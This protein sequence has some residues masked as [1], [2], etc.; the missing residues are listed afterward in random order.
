M[1]D[2]QIVFDF[3]E[4]KMPF[5]D[6][7]KVFS[8]NP[9]IAVW[10]DE[11]ADF[12]HR[13]IPDD[14]YE[15]FI[16]IQ[17]ICC[18]IDDGHIFKYLEKN[19]YPPQDRFT[20]EATARCGIFSVVGAALTAAYPEVKPTKYYQQEDDFYFD[21]IPEALMN[22]ELEEYFEQVLSEFPASMGKTKR[23][24]A[25]REK[26]K[27]LFHIEGRKYPRWAQESEWPMGKNSPMKFI[28][29]KQD[30]DQ[31]LFWFEDVD[32]GEERVIEQ[33]Y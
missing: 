14:L 32:T 12:K 11:I 4:G 19:P 25:A 16:G 2:K 24:K 20:R 30:E 21:A 17:A 15:A 29:Q 13:P 10:L 9:E 18:K 7:W 26:I 6:F 23:K 28:R 8:I 31:V 27:E 22:V 3:V 1:F 33:F 5:D